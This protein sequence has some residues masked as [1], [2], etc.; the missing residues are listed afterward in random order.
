[1]V[2]RT[3]TL[4]GLVVLAMAG[5][6]P[7][8]AHGIGGRSDLPVPVSYFIVGAAV[9]L[10]LSFAALAILWPEPRLQEP[11]R[12]RVVGRW[13]R[14]PIVL[15]A[16]VGLVGLA[17][18][19]GAGI[20]GEDRRTNAAPVLLWVYFWLVLPF[21]GAITGDLY[22]YLN[23]WRTM[24]GDRDRRALP[25]VGSLGIWP[26]TAA[27]V[28]FTWLELVHT[29]SANPIVLGTA[30]LLYSLYL[31]AAVVLTDKDT[32]FGS[33][34][35]FTSYNAYIGAI[36]PLELDTTGEWRWHGWLRRL[37]QLPVRRGMAV[38]VAAM[39]GTVTY[40][41]LSSTEWWGDTWGSRARDEWFGTIAIVATIALIYGA[42]WL[43]SWGAARAG[44]GSLSASQV[45]SSF[46]HTLVPI[47]LAYAVAHYFTLIIFEGQLLVAV[48]S[49]PLGLGSDFLGTAANRINFWLSPTSI[50][51]VQLTAILTGHVAA[52][53]L[54][55]DRALAIFPKDRAVRS[56]YAML[57]LMVALTGLGLALL[58]AG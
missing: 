14:W 26:A 56:Q 5:A 52:I 45:A 11:S 10:A 49:D 51:Y 27:F 33:F 19:I 25:A 22:R 41:G 3:L 31:G 20:L 18:V 4:I 38:F 36:A 24:A 50:W 17:L 57:G 8:S 12:G 23:P 29:D 6:A 28:A 7:A 48:A 55:H 35:A 32:A 30:A 21:V 46:A 44:G 47:A 39:I 58:A 34:D 37:P 53:V 42:Y 15:A 40:D 13:G 43:A 1:V 54:A 16:G 9:V 2:R